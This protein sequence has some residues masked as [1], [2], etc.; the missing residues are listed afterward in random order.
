[1]VSSAAASPVG[2]V[3][4]HQCL[5][6]RRGG[7]RRVPSQR[8]DGAARLLQPLAREL[9]RPMHSRQHDVTVGAVFHEGAGRL[10]LDGQAGQGVGEHIVDLARD[11][12]RLLEPR[13]PQLLLVRALGL[14]QQQLGLLGPERA[15]AGI[16]R[17]Q[18]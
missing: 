7:H 2:P 1:M 10:E 14:G 8:A 6:P 9:V 16:G 3:V 4:G 12:R 11:P 5:D 13:G 17:G 18:E 15:L